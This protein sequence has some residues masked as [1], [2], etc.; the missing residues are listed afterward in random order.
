LL[1]SI[2]HFLKTVSP[3]SCGWVLSLGAVDAGLA[4]APLTVNGIVD[5]GDYSDTSLFSVPSTAG[6]SYYVTLD[7]SPIPT[8]VNTV[9]AAQDFHLL[10][11]SRTNLTTLAVSNRVVRFIVEQAAYNHTERG[12]PVW[13]PYP[14]I[15][16]TAAELVGAQLRVITPQV[17]PLGLEIPVVTWIEKPDGSAVR[18]NAF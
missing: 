3:S 8:D 14:P 5:Q 6:Y 11:I 1:C 17:F 2:V 16:A 15:N 4:Q 7:G 13:T 12:Y 18:A 10:V 9:V